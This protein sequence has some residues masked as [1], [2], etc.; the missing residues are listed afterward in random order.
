MGGQGVVTAEPAR[1][2]AVERLD[3]SFVPD[4]S[5][6]R[7]EPVP[8]VPAV[9]VVRVGRLNSQQPVRRD[10]LVAQGCVFGDYALPPEVLVLGQRP[11]VDHAACDRRIVPVAGQYPSPFPCQAFLLRLYRGSLPRLSY[12]DAQGFGNSSPTARDSNSHNSKKS[13]SHSLVRPEARAIR[14]STSP[15]GG[16]S[17]NSSI[18]A[19]STFMWRSSSACTAATSISKDAASRCSMISCRVPATVS[20]GPQVHSSSLIPTPSRFSSRR[21]STCRP[22]SA[23]G[24]RSRWRPRGSHSTCRG[25]SGPGGP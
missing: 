21:S 23:D 4:L 12:R 3:D 15:S 2:D 7:G 11:H 8:L 17:G 18:T 20:P 19:S 22:G 10:H 13:A 25:P 6:E 1:Q 5:S 9:R 24:W 14:R 16:S